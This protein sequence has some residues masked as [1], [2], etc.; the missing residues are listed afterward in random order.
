MLERKLLQH[1]GELIG[2]PIFFFET[3]LFLRDGFENANRSKNR[4]Y[5]EPKTASSTMKKRERL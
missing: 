1:T 5:E 3:M 4:A 2:Q